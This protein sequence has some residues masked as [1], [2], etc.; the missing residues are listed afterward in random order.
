MVAIFVGRM[1]RW[2]TLSLLVLELGPGAVQ[3]VAHHALTAFLLVIAI[4]VLGFGIWWWK[5][6]R[7]ANARAAQEASPSE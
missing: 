2:L 5:R 4:A 7:G 1:V 6:K 3:L